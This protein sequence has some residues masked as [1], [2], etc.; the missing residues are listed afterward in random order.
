MGVVY[1]W[2]GVVM[3]EDQE[4]IYTDGQRAA[5]V[6]VLRHCC[7][8]LGVDDPEADKIRWIAQREMTVSMLR[9][10][11]EQHGDNDWPD[12]AYLPDVIEKH[13]WRHLGQ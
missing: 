12:D 2:E 3:T 4:L 8:E 5:Y 9:Q 11:C 13:L 6:D 1:E 10:V 7:R